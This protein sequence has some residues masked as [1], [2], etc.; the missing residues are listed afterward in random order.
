M[1]RLTKGD[2]LGIYLRSLLFVL[3]SICSLIE[4]DILKDARLAKLEYGHR[5]FCINLLTVDGVNCE[6]D[7]P[8][9]LVDHFRCLRLDGSYFVHLNFLSAHGNASLQ[10][11][12]CLF[13]QLRH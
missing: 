3:L 13:F 1:F 4:S 10:F 5:G 7:L 11:D 8:P 9:Q 2:N 12:L 6:V